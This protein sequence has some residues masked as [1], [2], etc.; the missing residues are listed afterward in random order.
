MPTTKQTL[1]KNTA[2]TLVT[3]LS[4]TTVLAACGTDSKTEGPSGTSAAAVSNEPMNVSIY[5]IQQGA[6]AVDPS[7]PILQ[8]I[9]KKTN[10]KLNITWSPLNSFNE[11]TKVMLASGDLADMTLVTN[12]FDSQVIQLATSG[13]FWDVTP[14]IKDYK[15]LSALPNGVW[16]NAKIKGKNYGVPRPRPLD[17]SWGVHLRKDWL[18][19]LGMKVP[20]TMDE[21]YEVLKAFTEKDPDGNG[22]ADTVGLTGQVEADGMGLYTWVEDTF[23]GAFGIFKMVGDQLAFIALEPSERKALE[24]LKKAYDEKVLTSDF[25]VIKMTQAREQ[26]MGGKAGALGSALNPQWLYTDAMRKI[27][28]KADSFP[29]TYLKTPD[30][31]KYAGQ[32][33]GNFGMYV[34]PKTVPEAKMKRILALI[35]Q[36]YNEEI[37]NLSLYGLPDTHYTVKDGMKVATAQAKTDNVADTSNNMAQIFQKFDKYQRAYYNGIPQDFYERSKKI[38]DDRAAFSTPNV[39]NGLISQTFLTNGPDLIKKIT[40]MKVKVIMGKESLAAWDEFVAK[41]KA[42]PNVQKIVKEINEAYKNK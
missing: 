19:K 5:T 32:D 10:T 34:I 16:D 26:Y 27:D 9:E 20:E 25:A 7:N 13:A 17:G 3:L 11:K 18:D 40:D 33:T 22:K 4:L 8:E 35:D 21:M 14:Y 29:L 39:G 12:I 6:Q 24:W 38:I 30:G 42:D 37:S 28:P 36:G 2:M 31:K 15:T 23:N 41:T 1:Y